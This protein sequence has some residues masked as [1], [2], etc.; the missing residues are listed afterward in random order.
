VL[1][2]RGT[3]TAPLLHRGSRQAGFELGLGGGLLRWRRRGAGIH[4]SN[5][6]AGGTGHGQW[7]GIATR[8]P[9]VAK[10]WPSREGQQDRRSACLQALLEGR[11]E[12][13]TRDPFSRSSAF[14]S[15]VIDCAMASFLSEKGRGPPL[16][17]WEQ[18]RTPSF[19]AAPRRPPRPRGSKSPGCR[20]RCP[21]PSGRSL[22]QGLA[23]FIPVAFEG[24][25][26]V[27]A[28][29]FER[30]VNFTGG[31]WGGGVNRGVQGV[32]LPPSYPPRFL[33]TWH[34]P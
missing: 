12:I 33:T 20:A 22:G 7:P 3:E 11:N 25:L 5:I 13:R 30:A 9:L 28:P 10:R 2:H 24:D 32:A 21:C 14:C 27:R 18:R 26:V 8:S 31:P 17:G 23:F 16:K 34:Y 1:L 6:V 29:G 15:A 4:R 19:V